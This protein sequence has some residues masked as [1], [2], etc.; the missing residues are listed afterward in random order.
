MMKFGLV[1]AVSLFWHSVWIIA[2]TTDGE[3]RLREHA[4]TDTIRGWDLGGISSVNLSQTSLTNWAAGGQNSLSVNGLLSLYGNYKTDKSVWD[5]SV[6]IGYGLLKQG[7]T[8]GFIKTD[9]KIDFTSKYGRKA[10]NNWY[11]AVLMNFKTQVT[12]GYNYSDDLTRISDFLSPAYLL[13]A[14]GM[15]YKPNSYFSLFVTPLTSKTTI[16]NSSLLADAGAYGVD[17]AITDSAGQIIVPGQKVRSEFGGYL[18]LVYSKSDFSREILK[19]ISLTTKVDLFSNYLDH[20][21]RMDVSWEILITLRINKF[22]SVNL[23]THL[24]YDYDVLFEMDDNNDGITD[25]TSRLIQ[26]KE[27]LGV[28][29]LYKF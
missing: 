10:L 7:K 1:I 6:D 21:E 17:P 26:F 14:L 5:N 25:R 20:P 3:K 8:D 28:G 23:N 4:A 13:V 19:N 22:I 18:R 29:F 9:D 24:L 27:I 2:Q 16:V 11:Y 12:Q 15:D